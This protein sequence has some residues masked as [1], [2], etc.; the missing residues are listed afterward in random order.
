M[1]FLGIR[2]ENLITIVL[3]LQYNWDEMLKF[4]HHLSLLFE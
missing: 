1:D 2:C 3:N 4:L